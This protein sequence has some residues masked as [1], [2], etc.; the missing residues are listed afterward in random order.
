MAFTMK[1]RAKHREGKLWSRPGCLEKP[2]QW[3]H[4]ACNFLPGKEDH[5]PSPDSSRRQSG[6]MILFTA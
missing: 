1:K 6:L 4:H 3:D 5:S 2:S